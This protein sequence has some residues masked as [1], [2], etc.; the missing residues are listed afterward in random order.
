MTASSGGWALGHG[1][2]TAGKIH[3]TAMSL[4]EDSGPLRLSCQL[5]ETAIAD[6]KA[7]RIGERSWND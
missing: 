5:P 4:N 3:C 7:F 2:A 1:L 6:Y